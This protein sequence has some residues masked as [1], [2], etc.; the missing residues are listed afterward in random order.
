MISPHLPHSIREVTE[1][2]ILPQTDQTPPSIAD[3]DVPIHNWALVAD[4]ETRKVL[5]GGGVL[6]RKVRY[7][8]TCRDVGRARST[9]L[10]GA[11]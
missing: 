9:P 5:E 7:S 6:E 3:L 10:F 4:E 8:L 2:H 11:K 1:D